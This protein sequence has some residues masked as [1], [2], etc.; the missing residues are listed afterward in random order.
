MNSHLGLWKISGI[1]TYLE[2]QTKCALCRMLCLDVH[3]FLPEKWPMKNSLIHFNDNFIQVLT[4]LKWY[5]YESASKLWITK[6]KSIFFHRSILHFLCSLRT[7]LPSFKWHII[8]ICLLTAPSL[9]MDRGYNPLIAFQLLTL[10]LK[11]PCK[12]QFVDSVH[13]S[14][15]YISN[16]RFSE[17]S[18]SHASVLI[19]WN[20]E[21]YI[22]DPQLNFR[23]INRL[24]VAAAAL[25]AASISASKSLV[26]GLIPIPGSTSVAD[27]P[28][29]Q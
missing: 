10:T 16:F 17:S 9:A 14:V 29:S 13:A 6:F 24:V 1:C 28:P 27:D 20:K 25:V 5:G 26:D 11:S 3:M 21:T 4:N 23:S 18:S 15:W 2:L 8:K 12:N 19:S 22:C 7:E